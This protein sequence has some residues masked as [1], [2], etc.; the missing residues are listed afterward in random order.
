ML[1]RGES[2]ALVAMAVGSVVCPAVSIAESPRGP[3]SSP[4]VQTERLEMDEAMGSAASLNTSFSFGSG[5]GM[6]G[7]KAELLSLELEAMTE[8]RSGRAINASSLLRDE[9]FEPGILSQCQSLFGPDMEIQERFR[10]GSL[11]PSDSNEAQTLPVYEGLTI[12]AR[13][14][15]SH[16]SLDPM[17][18]SYTS[19]SQ[20]ENDR[21]NL[22]N[23]RVV[24]G[25]FS[26]LVIGVIY[27][28]LSILT[29]KKS[30][31]YY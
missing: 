18:E 24:G 31:S 27:V 10:G 21:R 9:Q 3:K 6:R 26:I 14:S 25:T 23:W 20:T 1:R 8:F 28:G 13:E 19:L 12:R 2:K 30:E 22:W 11:I 17:D 4:S 5:S 16:N 7:G 29:F 15:G